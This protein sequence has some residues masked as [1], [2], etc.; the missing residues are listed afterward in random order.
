MITTRTHITATP[1]YPGSFLPEDGRPKVIADSSP[2]T[3]ISS[4]NDDGR[5]FC[6]E[7]KT[8]TQKLWTDGDGGEKW[9]PGGA[10]SSY[11]IYIGEALTAADVEGLD[12]GDDH[13]I[14]LSNMRGNGWKRVVR[15]RRGNW[16][17]VEP[18]DVVLAH[19]PA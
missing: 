7:V 17:P 2:H 13:T 19:V 9:M 18:G 10:S 6:L 15:T 1:M 3:A 4:I 5:W 16:Q 12:D 8:S 14:L 11:R